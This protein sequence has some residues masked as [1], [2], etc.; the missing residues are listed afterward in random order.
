M[1]DIVEL[2]PSLKEYLWGGTK[3]KSYKDINN[4]Y[5]KISESWELSFL[6]EGPSLFIDENDNKKLKE[7]RKEVNYKKD[8][9]SNISS[10]V[11]NN[12][13][14]FPTLIKLI[15]SNDSLSIQVHPSD[16]YALK[17]E[18]SLG[19]E[20]MRIILDSLPSSYLYLGLNKDLTKED[21]VK[22]IN[23]NNLL[24]LLNK[25]MVKKGDIFLIKPG[26]IHA[27][28]KGITLLEIQ[29]S[30]FLTYR[31]YDYNRIDKKSGKKRELHIKKAIDVINLKK[32]DLSTITL[33]N[34]KEIKRKYFTCF[35][36]NLN[37]N[38]AKEYLFNDSF[39][40][41]TVIEGEGYINNK[42]VSKYKSYF[43]KANTK[44]LIKS[45]SNIKYVLTKV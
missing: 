29:E 13:L 28:G 6:D 14:F 31:L 44:F 40:C 2:I 24:S 15:D 21:F 11:F 27:I 4:K 25:V 39:S 26:T 38:E 37:K 3:L 34:E 43:I 23:D 45:H 10:F 22:S 1:E 42:K 32:L 7:V 33:T 36:E 41:L 18:N 17:Y 19:K 8:L 9:G 5:E 35:L 20:E 12:K 16:E 30:S